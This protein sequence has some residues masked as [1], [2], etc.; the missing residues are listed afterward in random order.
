LFVDPHFM[1]IALQC[2]RRRQ[3]GD[4]G[5]D[6]GNAHSPIFILLPV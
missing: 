6:D 1:A 5:T 3:P 2:Q 4:A